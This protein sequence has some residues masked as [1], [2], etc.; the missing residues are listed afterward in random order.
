MI[1][2]AFLCFFQHGA[3]SFGKDALLDR[4]LVNWIHFGNHFVSDRLQLLLVQ[5]NQCLFIID[6]QKGT[7]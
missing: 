7:P 4:F 2:T 6:K 1:V 3:N 5:V